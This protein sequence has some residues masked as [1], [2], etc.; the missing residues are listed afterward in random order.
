ME[1]LLKSGRNT[2]FY[3]Y[4]LLKC[5]QNYNRDLTCPQIHKDKENKKKKK[6]KKRIE[7]ETTEA[8]KQMDWC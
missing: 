2:L 6:K 4:S 8:K 7:N 3:L 1:F 5:H